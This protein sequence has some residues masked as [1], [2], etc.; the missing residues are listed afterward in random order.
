M[1]AQ[2]FALR[3]D[4]CLSVGRGDIAALR[5]VLAC[6]AD[7]LRAGVVAGVLDSNDN[8]RLALGHWHRRDGSPCSIQ[9][10]RNERPR[11]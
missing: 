2:H 9:R 5:D 7:G 3:P 1:S 10:A 8:W 6:T 11:S 4:D